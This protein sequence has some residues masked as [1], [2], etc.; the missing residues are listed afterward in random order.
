MIWLKK[1]VFLIFYDCLGHFGKNK[2]IYFLAVP[3]TVTWDK[4]K[5]CSMISLIQYKNNKFCVS[6]SILL[7]G[8][9]FSL[10]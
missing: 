2:C 7:D 10:F 4:A 5:L 6:K 1:D 8:M 3:V 9:G